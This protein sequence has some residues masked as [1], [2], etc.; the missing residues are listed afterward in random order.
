MP[1][2][3]KP[4][5]HGEG[6]PEAAEHFNAAEQRFVKSEGGKQKI[7]EGAQV[8]PDEEAGLAEAEKIGR[9]HAKS[10]KPGDTTTQK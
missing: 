1:M 3:K 10:A 4:V 2:D 6:N 5:N 8:R 9:D 7:R